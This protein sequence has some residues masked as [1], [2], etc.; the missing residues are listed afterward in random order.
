MAWTHFAAPKFQL[1]H[2]SNPTGFLSSRIL[3]EEVCSKCKPGFYIYLEKFQNEM[4]FAHL[5]FHW[6]LLEIQLCDSEQHE[7]GREPIIISFLREKISVLTKN[8]EFHPANISFQS[9]KIKFALI[10]CKTKGFFSP[11]RAS[12]HFPKLTLHKLSCCSKSWVVPKFVT[13]KFK[14]PRWEI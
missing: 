8:T 3:G 11:W 14:R 7:N 13:T 12:R 6:N 10:H 2:P 9:V 1:R 5:F 4:M